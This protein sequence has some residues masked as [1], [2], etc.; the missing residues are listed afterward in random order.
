VNL[1]KVHLESMNEAIRKFLEES[2]EVERKWRRK[3]RVK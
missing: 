2:E 1:T 3:W